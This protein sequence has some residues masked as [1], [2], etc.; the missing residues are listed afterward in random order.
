MVKIDNIVLDYLDIHNY[1]VY[2][3]STGINQNTKEVY[4]K[5]D[6][7]G[8]HSH[9]SHAIHDLINRLILRKAKDADSVKALLTEMKQIETSIKSQF[10]GLLDIVKKKTRRV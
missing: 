2:E 5:K 1:I 10:E 9:W 4:D 3:A 8:Y 6:S 7:V